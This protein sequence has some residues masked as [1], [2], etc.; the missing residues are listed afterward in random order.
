L[1]IAVTGRPAV[2]ELGLGLTVSDRWVPLAPGANGTVMA[3]WQGCFLPCRPAQILVPAISPIGAE[4]L[5][6]GRRVNGRRSRL[7]S[8]AAGAIDPV[9]ATWTM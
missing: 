2:A 6:R 9:S 1:Q 4:S 7:R 3:R 5:G 8:D